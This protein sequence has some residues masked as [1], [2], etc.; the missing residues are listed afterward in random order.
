M[1]LFE[2]GVGRP[3]NEIKKQRKIFIASAITLC[4]ALVSVFAFALTKVN[5]NNM[6]GAATL[7]AKDVRLDFTVE[8]SWWSGQGSEDKNFNIHIN[9][10]PASAKYY[11]AIS[12]TTL[13][14]CMN[15]N[16]WN[17]ALSQ[18]KTGKVLI[19]TTDKT[20]KVRGT[21]PKSLA[22][23]T[24]FL[25]VTTYNAADKYLSVDIY[26]I[27][28]GS[29]TR[30]CK[31]GKCYAA[32]Q[33]LVASKTN[34]DYVK[35]VN[36]TNPTT[37]SKKVK[38][39][40]ITAEYKATE[41]SGSSATKKIKLKMG[42]IGSKVEK[43]SIVVCE[44]AADCEK[45]NAYELQKKVNAKSVTNKKFKKNDIVTMELKTSSKSG[46]NKTVYV[47]ITTYD[48]NEKIL[49]TKIEKI[50]TSS[51][52]KSGSKDTYTFGEKKNHSSKFHV[53][54][55]EEFSLTCPKTAMTQVQ[56]Q[57][58]ANQ[59]GVKFTI[60]A[61]KATENGL[62]TSNEATKTST[63]T[64]KFTNKLF[65]LYPKQI[66]KDSQGEYISTV[67]YAEKDGKKVSRNVKVYKNT[68]GTGAVGMNSTSRPV[69]KIELA[70]PQ[71]IK[72]GQSFKCATNV[73][74]VKLSVPAASALDTGYKGSFVTTNKDMSIA[75]KFNS[76]LF[77]LYPKQIKKDS[78]GEYI[79]TVIYAE[80]DGKKIAKQ[81]K[82]YK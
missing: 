36:T 78:K 44:K 72:V 77:S 39:E 52:V 79:S 70:C 38:K 7:N 65:E 67:I 29:A 35:Q 58:T 49:S 34:K 21:N 1:K 56:F 43:A 31:A 46:A 9:K 11:I 55:E 68:S 20:A 33:K 59:D 28:V 18:N 37:K 82:V 3:S 81:V 24:F 2:N 5:V 66:K 60:P 40:D 64:V 16:A 54:V 4:I 57:C 61:S 6:K 50:K 47:K 25:R 41:L 76:K 27:K 23:T 30:N 73:S 26:E 45:T 80:K 74:G 19:T 75:I 32:T 15:D 48:K 42:K 12:C 63:L 22:N 13:S 53:E 8:N 17:K 71:T 10:K 14:E 51:K 62:G 69:Q